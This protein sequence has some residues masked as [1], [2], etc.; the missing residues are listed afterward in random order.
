MVS[1]NAKR[2]LI[3]SMLVPG[4]RRRT[5]RL[6]VSI[7][8]FS[9][10]Q[11]FDVDQQNP[12]ECLNFFVRNSQCKH[13][14]LGV[15]HDS[16]YAS[17]LGRF[18]ADVSTRDRITLLEGDTIN[19]RI[20]ALGFRNILKLDT[21]FAPQTIQAVPVLPSTFVGAPSTQGLTNPA[22]L[23][24]RLGPVLRNES[25]QRVDKKLHIDPSTPYIHALRQAKMCAWYYLR[26]RCESNCDKNH[27]TPALKS[28]EFDFLWFIA[29]HGLCFKMRKEKDCDDPLCVYGHEKGCPIGTGNIRASSTGL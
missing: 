23:S 10:L 20:R 19:P 5:T 18:A 24:D 16:G 8:G 2:Y 9:K 3:S 26:G 21:V 1:I 25:G 28:K 12:T 29:R 17:S 22:A 6:G 15:C 4:R 7:S 13:I 14:V 11:G 27:F